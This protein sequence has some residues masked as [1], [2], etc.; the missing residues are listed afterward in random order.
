MT[1]P[2]PE[3]HDLPE[4]GSVEY[5]NLAH[6]GSAPPLPAEP[7]VTL[8]PVEAEDIE[9]PGRDEVDE[10]VPSAD[11]ADAEE[12]L[13]LPWWPPRPVPLPGI[14]SGLGLKKFRDRLPQP[15]IIRAWR[16]PENTPIRVRAELGRVQFHADIPPAEAWTY[17]GGLPGPTIEVQR[18][19][20]VRID[21][22]N[23]LER[24][25]AA[26]KL[27]YDVV[28]V[29]ELPPLPPGRPGVN[30]NFRAAA[31]PGGRAADRG[32]GEDSYPRLEHTDELTAATVVHLHGALTDGHND[33]WH[34][35]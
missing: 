11:R 23:G 13:G 31:L 24:D 7:G 32:P 6:A 14:D 9:E 34:T 30:A 20:S 22:E 12:P 35:T 15:T 25:G 5:A 1:T 21:W 18:D 28:R 3:S 16:R 4:P 26:L 27:P 10:R 2:T 19:R 8:A 33:G 29:P 17:E